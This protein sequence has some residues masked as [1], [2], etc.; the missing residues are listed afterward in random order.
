M[1]KRTKRH[2][3]TA[4]TDRSLRLV[5][6]GGMWSEHFVLMSPI[7]TEQCNIVRE[8]GGG[9]YSTSGL[10]NLFIPSELKKIGGK[11]SGIYELSVKTP[12]GRM[13]VVYLGKAANLFTRLE[14]HA[15]YSH[16]RENK[17]KALVRG[18]SILCRVHITN[19]NNEAVSQENIALD[20][21]EFHWN[22]Q[23]QNKEGKKVTE[24]FEDYGNDI[25]QT[26][27]Q[28]PK[29]APRASKAPKA[30]KKYFQK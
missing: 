17:N 19:D 7:K 12:D 29:K 4:S 8:K 30:V 21:Y 14:D 15:R 3:V 24:P 23:R 25:K 6:N 11:V 13:E 5:W 1:K 18:C 9:Y 26:G 28:S 2:T 20:K 22:I 27:R 10:K 16:K